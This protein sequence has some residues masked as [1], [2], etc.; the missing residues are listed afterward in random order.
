MYKHKAH[1]RHIEGEA[2]FLWILSPDRPGSGS[3]NDLP[4][5]QEPFDD[6]VRLFAN[7]TIQ[8]LGNSVG[9]G[10][11]DLVDRT[12]RNPQLIVAAFRS[13]NILTDTTTRGLPTN[14]IP[15]PEDVLWTRS[16]R[17]RNIAFL[18]F[19]RESVP[20]Q[21]RR[22]NPLFDHAGLRA[23]NFN[24]YLSGAGINI[25][26]PN[27]ALLQ[28]MLDTVS[29]LQG[30][31]TSTAPGPVQDAVRQTL[32][33]LYPAG[34]IGEKR[35][36]ADYFECVRLLRS[37]RSSPQPTN[38]LL[39]TRE[40]LTQ[41]LQGR[42]AP[43]MPRR[44]LSW[45]LHEDPSVVQRTLS[46]MSSRINQG[47]VNV[48]FERS[49][50]HED[51]NKLQSVVN[52]SILDRTL[53]FY[54]DREPWQQ[55]AMIGLGLWATYKLLRSDSNFARAGRILASGV[56]GWMAFEKFVLGHD[57]SQMHITQG[58]RSL[59]GLLVRDF[60]PENRQRIE[61]MS[62]F[63]DE[64]IY[65]NANLSSAFV[66]LS[67]MRMGDIASSLRQ[68]PAGLSFH[69]APNIQ[70]PLRQAA[71]RRGLNPDAVSG[72]FFAPSQ[73]IQVASLGRTLPDRKSVV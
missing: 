40:L 24:T 14:R 66:T 56:V 71:S 6:A 50:A 25:A 63:L 8:F 73:P 37:D 60:G 67:S 43:E 11:R 54:N 38:E 9:L 27:N 18:Q 39:S 19:I 21:T 30:S 49:G 36:Y 1:F 7:R 2:R 48:S 12:M 15:T 68:D 52:E 55:F 33:E 28:Q 35:L 16:V 70:G 31:T 65:M 42:V 4:P 41:R 58:M 62:K 3:I 26:P 59:Q 17:E 20:E 5:S 69:F 44:F 13:P 72:Q 32:R 51:L 53:Q 46:S 64:R 29:C 57:L 22:T 10:N 45:L 23:A 61:I 34:A 47:G